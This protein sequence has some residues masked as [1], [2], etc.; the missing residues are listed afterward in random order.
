WPVLATEGGWVKVRTDGGPGWIGGGRVIVRSTPAQL[1]CS[2]SR[3]LHVAG[4]VQTYVPT[5]CLSLRAT[6]SREA[7]ML[8]CVPN[9]TE[10]LVSDGPYDPGTGED[11]FLVYSPETGEGWVLADH[12]YSI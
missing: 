5:G 4:Y 3:F 1:D 10:Y 2:E 11:W 8:A 6:P 7:R 12:I 9:G